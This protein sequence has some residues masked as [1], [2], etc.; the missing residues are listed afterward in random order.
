MS[1]KSTVMPTIKIINFCISFI[2]MS[3]NFN[4]LIMASIIK[5][6]IGEE[7]ER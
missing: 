2:I 3:D 1:V 7:I 5:L 4:P 6:R